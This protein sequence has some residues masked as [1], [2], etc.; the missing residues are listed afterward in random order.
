MRAGWRLYLHGE[1]KLK[2]TGSLQYKGFYVSK[3]LEYIHTD[4]YTML[5]VSF[6]T[7]NSLYKNGCIKE[8][9]SSQYQEEYFLTSKA[10][11][12]NQKQ[13]ITSEDKKFMVMTEEIIEQAKSRN[14]SWN[15][16]QFK[17]IGFNFCERNW[18][19]RALGRKYPVEIINKYIEIRNDHLN[20]KGN[21]VLQQILLD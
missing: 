15:G 13:D 1:G 6:S 19:Q 21:N 14:G 10:V 5:L 11:N 7:I 18:K 8:S 17:L 20:K 9:K 2:K 12:Y 4:E 16:K 3:E